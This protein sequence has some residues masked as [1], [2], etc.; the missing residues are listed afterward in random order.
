[1]CCSVGHSHN[2]DPTLLWLWHRL[3]AIASIQPLAWELPHALVRP[4]KEKKEK[5]RKAIIFRGERI[6]HELVTLTEDSYHLICNSYILII[7]SLKIITNQIK[8]SK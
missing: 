3:A 5:E 8:L 4:K 1:M 7:K 6:S 2:L